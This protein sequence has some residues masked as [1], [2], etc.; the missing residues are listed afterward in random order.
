MNWPDFRIN[1]I[2]GV[3]DGN[4]ATAARTTT[5]SYIS[6]DFAQKAIISQSII[7]TAL[8]IALTMAICLY[9]RTCQV[10]R[11][12]KK[13]YRMLEL[14]EIDALDQLD[15][16]IQLL[17]GLDRNLKVDKHKL[18]YDKKVMHMCRYVEIRKEF[19]NQLAWFHDWLNDMDDKDKIVDRDMVKQKFNE[20]SKPG[21]YFVNLWN[22]QLISWGWINCID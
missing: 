5:Y 2:T 1:I 4:A 12:V 20:N 14:E 15:Y 19:L 22:Q 7:A 6:D 11:T 3:H 21:R 9:I 13:H 8:L 17:E 18:K 16:L 10:E